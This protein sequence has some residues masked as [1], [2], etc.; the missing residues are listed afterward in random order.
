MLLPTSLLDL[1]LAAY[2]GCPKLRIV[3]T[4]CSDSGVESNEH[5]VGLGMIS[6]SRRF[7]VIRD[8]MIEQILV[9][10]IELR[11]LSWLEKGALTPWLL[12]YQPL[13]GKAS[14]SR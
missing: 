4:S 6:G 13:A 10:P 1:R 7:N 11:Y 2:E 9:D 3:E 5:S 14:H 8:A 12:V